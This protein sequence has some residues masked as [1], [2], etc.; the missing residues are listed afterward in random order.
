MLF[1]GTREVDIVA[2]NVIYNMINPLVALFLRCIY[3]LLSSSMCIVA[4]NYDVKGVRQATCAR[5]SQLGT[6]RD[7]VMTKS[8]MDYCRLLY[9]TMARLH[10]LLDGKRL[11]ERPFVWGRI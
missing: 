6:L 1:S 3:M 10:S 4:M 5:S 7:F 8:I 2:C 11:N 9:S